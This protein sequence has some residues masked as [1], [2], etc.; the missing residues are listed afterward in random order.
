MGRCLS[1]FGRH[2]EKPPP[3]VDLRAKYEARRLGA[4]ELLS[5]PEPGVRALAKRVV[6]TSDAWIESI[7]ANE[8]KEKPRR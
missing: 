1:T 7:D 8:R 6:D 3:G 2:K 4:M 5:H